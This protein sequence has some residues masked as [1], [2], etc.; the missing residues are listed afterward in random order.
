M[1]AQK[2]LTNNLYSIWISRNL[3]EGGGQ[4]IL[5]AIDT[6][7]YS[8]TISYIP[9]TSKK[10]WSIVFT[11]MSLGSTIINS[12]TRAVIDSG[13][14]LILGPTNAITIIHRTIKAQFYG[15]GLYY[16]DCATVNRLP[17]VSLRLNGRSYAM[18][19]N[20]YIVR[21]L[22][23]CFSGFSPLDF[24]N[25]EGQISWVLGTAFLGAYYT[26]FDLPNARVGLATS[27]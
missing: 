15:N 4:F 25:D 19:S 9:V 23:W 6:T 5:G 16:V 13:S 11:N 10:W 2:L 24:R 26:I 12:G 17:N 18:R 1:I 8:G 3:G 7:R 22:G 21:I 27:V 20:R 14:S